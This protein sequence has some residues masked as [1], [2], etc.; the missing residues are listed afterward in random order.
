M[1]DN[2]KEII[3]SG[4][5]IIFALT[6]FSGSYFLYS[7]AV[8][9]NLFL[10]FVSMGCLIGSAVIIAPYLASL[11][12]KPMGRL[13]YSGE[14]FD[15]PQPM[16]SIPEGK[17]KSGDYQEAFDGFQKIANEYPQE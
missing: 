15:R 8:S 5:K 3:S 11:L 10:G 17:R 13:F 12:A 2:L 6:L 1:I 14:Q 16:Y 7:A 9:G 4:L